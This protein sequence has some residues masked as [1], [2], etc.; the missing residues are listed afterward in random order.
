MPANLENLPSS[1]TTLVVV[2][3]GEDVFQ[4]DLFANL[5][6]ELTTLE[7]WFNLKDEQ[8][9]GN[10]LPP[11][12][13]SLIISD[14]TANFNWLKKLPASLIKLDISGEAPLDWK[15]LPSGLTELDVGYPCEIPPSALSLLPKGIHS[16]SVWVEGEIRDSHMA[17][18]PRSLKSFSDFSGKITHEGLQLAPPGLTELSVHVQ[19]THPDMIA[20]YHP[21]SADIRFSKNDGEVIL[22]KPLPLPLKLRSF[23]VHYMTDEICQILPPELQSLEILG[24][25]ITAA[26]AKIFPTLKLLHNFTSAID[27]IQDDVIPYLKQISSLSF[28]ADPTLEREAVR[29]SPNFFQLLLP[30]SATDPVPSS[31]PTISPSHS[32]DLVSARTSIDHNTKPLISIHLEFNEFYEGPLFLPKAIFS[33]LGELTNLQMLS[34]CSYSHNIKGAWLGQFP[35]SLRSLELGVLAKCPE[36]SH[37][38]A[39]PSGLTKLQLEVRTADPHETYSTTNDSS[40]T[41]QDMA[42]LPRNLTSLRINCKMTRL[43]PALNQYTPLYLSEFR[44]GWSDFKLFQNPLTRV[45]GPSPRDQPAS[46]DVEDEDDFL[47]DPLDGTDSSNSEDQ[48]F[49]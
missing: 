18:L 3:H 31:P 12:L 13:T 26:G 47:N 35:A 6:R 29:L 4:R 44:V 21:E 33:W 43:T 9:D 1:L 27:A 28:T 25:N 22:L 15:T 32:L 17:D 42:L 41:D 10:E 30:S 40:W 24:G 37:L 34:I 16:L 46:E 39:L 38:A 7:C 14:I 36:P 5:P 2:A 20:F 48:G 8:E 11:N 19:V 49:F 45:F 23:A